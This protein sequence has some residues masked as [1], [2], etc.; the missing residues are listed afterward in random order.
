M[1]PSDAALRGLLPHTRGAGGTGALLTVLTALQTLIKGEGGGTARSERSRPA[2]GPT[3][4]AA[5]AHDAP[6]CPPAAA[7]SSTCPSLPNPAPAGDP[8]NVD[9][10][11]ARAQQLVE[12]PGIIAMMI[13]AAQSARVEV[14][15]AARMLLCQTINAS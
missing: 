6:H 10:V 8:P 13:T 3:L 15:D 5:S 9:G 12:E 4:A 14:A 11:A 1:T 2:R 7:P